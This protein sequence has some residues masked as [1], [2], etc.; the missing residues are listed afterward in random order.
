M[1]SFF[2]YNNNG[3]NMNTIAIIGL[4]IGIVG[5]ILIIAITIYNKYQYS[6]IK[7]NKGETNISLHLEQKYDI[8]LRYTDFLR[9]NILIN[10][11]DFEEYNTINLKQ[12]INKINKKLNKLNNEINKYL[13]NNEQLLKNDV[14][15]NLEKELAEIDIK[16]NGCKK[17]YN[18]N[19]IVYNH[20]CKAFPSSII[21]KI[22]KYKEKDFIDD[23]KEEQLKILED[24]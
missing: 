20:L 3:D 14:V 7:I 23:T 2:L 8:L 6:L 16:V 11:E 1:Y 17:Y 13:D 18:D 4:I 15:I 9:N 22:F 19:L 12:S 10:E 5:I 24:E 21:G